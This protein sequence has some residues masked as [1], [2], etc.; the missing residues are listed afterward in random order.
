MLKYI[1]KKFL[2]GFI[3]I[4]LLFGL[5]LTS[6]AITNEQAKVDKTVEQK[7]M[8]SDCGLVDPSESELNYLL[9]RPNLVDERIKKDIKYLEAEAEEQFENSMRESIG[10]KSSWYYEE[11]ARGTD[12]TV[13]S[14]HYDDSNGSSSGVGQNNHAA[15]YSGNWADASAHAYGVGSAQA[16]AA[17]GPKIYITG[18]GT[19]NADIFYNFSYNGTIAAASNGSAK[20]KIYAELW[21]ANGCVAR[22]TI[23]DEET[24]LGT[25][26]YSAT[27]TGR[28][29]RNLTAGQ[30]YTIVAKVQTN[31]TNYG[32]VTANSDFWN[33]GS[34]PEGIAFSHII[35]DWQ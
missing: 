10:I 28:F 19:Q 25:D 15:S 11:V 2:M 30:T 26:T 9:A 20:V 14:C 4:S 27:A 17:V 31:A 29:N 12:E 22:H 6:L 35:V 1:A 34:G 7:I 18:T 33:G 16:W 8:S 24:G 32:G 23:L 13:T 5:P 21:D 3:C